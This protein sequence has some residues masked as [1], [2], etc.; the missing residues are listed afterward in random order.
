MSPLT[1][2]LISYWHRLPAESPPA[3]RRALDALRE[4]IRAGVEPRA[5]V[6]PFAIGDVD[7]GIV[8]GAT[9]CYLTADGR[10]AATCATDD[11]ITE[12][13]DWVRRGLA[14]NR[15]AVFGALLGLEDER[16]GESLASSRLGLSAAEVETACRVLGPVPGAR[17]AAFLREWLDLIGDSARPRERRALAALLDG[18][19]KARAA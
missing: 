16:A 7:D 1:N 4:R 8:A 2:A 19:P 11:A 18:E 12:C 3:R 14:L 9:R 5:A 10:P 13:A 15:G 6:L 17:A